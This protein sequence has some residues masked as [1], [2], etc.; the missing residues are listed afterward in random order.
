MKNI[1]YII[2]ISILFCYKHIYAQVTTDFNNTTLITTKGRFF[3][4]YDTKVDFLIPAK[5]IKELEEV[6]KIS[7]KNIANLKYLKIAT[8]IS[9][10]L[11]LPKLINWTFDNEYAYGKYTIKLTNALSSSINFDQFFL[12]K[13]TEMYVYNENGNMITGVITELENNKNN[14]WGSWVYKGELLTIEIK[15]P[16][17]TKEQLILHA[18]NIAYGYKEMYKTKVGGFGLAGSCNINVLCPL[19]IGW[20]AE[21][22]SV[23]LG[24]SGD[25]SG[26]FSG[27][28]IMNTCGND[29][30]YFL[31]ANH[32]YNAAKPIQNV[33]GWRFTFQAW[34]PTCPNPGTNTNGIMYNGSTLKSTWTNSDFCLVEL[35]NIPALNSGIHY[36]GWARTTLGQNTTGIHHPSGDLMKI[37][38]ATNPVTISSFTGFPSNHH[39]Q[40]NWTLGVTEGGSSGSP[41][42]D[43]NHRIIGQLSGGPSFC[44]SSQLWDFYGRFDL[45]WTGGG[46]NE[47]RLSNWLDPSNSNA[48]TTN[49]TNVANLANS[50][51]L[52]LG[53]NGSPNYFCNIGDNLTF[54]ITGLPAN[55]PIT[56]SLSDNTVASIIGSNTSPTVIISKSAINNGYVNLIATATSCPNNYVVSKKITLGTGNTTVFFSQLTSGCAIANK[57]YF[58]GAVEDFQGVTNYQWYSKDM[59]NPNNPFVL[60]QENLGPTADFP[61]S[62]NRY[63]TIRVKAITPCGIVSS[64][65]GEGLIYASSCINGV[66]RISIS[67]NPASS[68]I[69]ITSIKNKDLNSDDK[70]DEFSVVEI[71]NKAGLLLLKKKLGTASKTITLNV[72]TLKADAYVVSVWNGTEWISEGF[73]KN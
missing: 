3:K 45:S 32:V 29:K 66:A 16:L 44:S 1:K 24:I 4:N 53:I 42:F 39:L 60:R 11:H 17:K 49:T 65:D 10:N 55:I 63:Y 27:S 70:I 41:L 71:R 62:K 47:T 57:P 34:S 19:G 38:R 13:G 73:I 46:T 54:N 37:S 64:I 33:T 8:P 59:S 48:L 51:N 69:K 21:R 25:G 26:T 58:W 61:L 23:A 40:A 9:V 56:W 5:S 14:V 2:I 22:N 28:M 31:T 50:S 72:S 20:E 18:N 52:T 6:D 15:T 12:P 68:N 35:N 7:L 67:P 30:A 43:Q 36:A